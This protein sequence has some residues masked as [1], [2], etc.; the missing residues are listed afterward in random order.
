MR[1]RKI[2]NTDAPGTKPTNC[3]VN[4]YNTD[5]LSKNLQRRCVAEP[6][7]CTETPGTCTQIPVQIY[8]R[9]DAMGQ[10]NKI[11]SRHISQQTHG[12][13]GQKRTLIH[14]I[15]LCHNKNTQQMSG[16]RLATTTITMT[17]TTTTMAGNVAGAA[18]GEQGG[19]AGAAAEAASALNLENGDDDGVVVD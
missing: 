3:Y 18:A 17:L 16:G 12:A 2:C 4:V 1:C 14:N 19:R 9:A 11:Q 13:S 6:E 10:E 7:T 5:A 8:I 15:I